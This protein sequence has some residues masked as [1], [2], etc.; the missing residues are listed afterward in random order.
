M[1]EYQLTYRQ[2]YFF[3]LIALGLFYCLPAIADKSELSVIELKHRTAEEIIPLLKPVLNTG[4][5][6]SGQGYQLIINATPEIKTQI[7]KILTDIDRPLQQFIITVEQYTDKVVSSH[8]LATENDTKIRRTHAYK[9]ENLRQKVRVMEGKAALIS[10]GQDIPVGTQAGIGVGFGIALLGNID[11]KKLQSG[12]IVTPRLSGEKVIL[13]IQTFQELKDRNEGGIIN[14]QET[15][16]TVSS[17]L[18]QWITLSQS[19]NEM[20]NG[21]NTVVYGTQK[22][23]L[24]TRGVR[25]KV[26]LAQDRQ[27]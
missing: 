4:D 6:V 5:T 7:K 9:D 10:T 20:D 19:N 27:P 18:G 3:V 2:L 16:T 1:I 24:R 23:Q 15:H 21:K 14:Q 17:T 26:M 13:E 8:S 25:V 22:H 11:Y 12:F